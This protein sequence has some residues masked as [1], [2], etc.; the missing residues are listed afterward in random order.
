MALFPT[1][2]VM[3]HARRM[4]TGTTHQKLIIPKSRAKVPGIV[5]PIATLF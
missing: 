2:T 3:S 1:N 5:S 4:F